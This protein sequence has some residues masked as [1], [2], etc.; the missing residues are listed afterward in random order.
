VSDVGAETDAEVAHQ[1][2]GY[3]NTHA[4]IEPQVHPGIAAAAAAEDIFSITDEQLSERFTFISEI[5]FGNW[6]SV[7][8]CKPKHPRASALVVRPNDPELRL[9]RAAAASG[10][11]GAGG[12]VAIKLVHREKSPVSGIQ[13]D[14]HGPDTCNA[15]DHLLRPPPRES[16]RSGGR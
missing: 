11:S 13:M 7:W 15:A 4:H 9:G 3:A 2:A 6:G 8:L 14:H 1:V 5:G 10:G 16:R 12:K